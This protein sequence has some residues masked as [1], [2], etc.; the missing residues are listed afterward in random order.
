MQDSWTEHSPYGWSPGVTKIMPINREIVL[1]RPLEPWCYFSSSLV[2]F[3][4]ALQ[5]GRGNRCFCQHWP[6]GPACTGGCSWDY[7]QAL[8][9]FTGSSVSKVSWHT[10]GVSSGTSA[11]Y[12]APLHLGHFALDSFPCVTACPGW[13]GH[14]SICFP[15]PWHLVLC[16]SC[17][18]KG[19]HQHCFTWSSS[20]NECEDCGG[21]CTGERKPGSP[22]I[23]LARAVLPWEEWGSP[24][25]VW[26][27]RCYLAASLYT[28]QCMAEMI[29]PSTTSQAASSLSSL[30]PERVASQA[31]WDRNS[32]VCLGWRDSWLTLCWLKVDQVTART[33]GQQHK[34]AFNYL[35]PELYRWE[36]QTVLKIFHGIS[37]LESLSKGKICVY[38]WLAPWVDDLTI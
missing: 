37:W 25:G 34:K 32:P 14:Q 18:S 21:P 31:D 4:K 17:V 11:R 29:S 13:C 38:C 28:F 2:R 20:H 24:R 12:S 33:S 19:M 1:R 8:Q 35:T 15:R 27:Y 16:S 22:W 30:S 3:L 9:L 26:S 36:F 6:H 7:A 5:R 10:I 23:P